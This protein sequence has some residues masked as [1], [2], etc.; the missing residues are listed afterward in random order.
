MKSRLSDEEIMAAMQKQGLGKTVAEELDKL[1]DWVPQDAK[2]GVIA[3]FA[4]GGMSALMLVA[5]RGFS[6]DACTSV[7]DELEEVTQ[8]LSAM[9]RK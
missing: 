9:T 8:A 4:A 1:L 7:R 6:K 3:A 2:Q 5:Q